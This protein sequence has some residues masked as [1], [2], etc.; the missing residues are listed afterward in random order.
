VSEFTVLK[1]AVDRGLWTV[2]VLFLVFVVIVFY[3]VL[4]GF[5]K[6][7][8]GKP[9]E[10]G[11]APAAQ[12]HEPDFTAGNMLGN[13]VMIVM[14]VSVILLG[15]RVPSFIDDTIRTCVQVLG[16]R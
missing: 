6:M 8:F 2:V 13:A 12:H 1:A 5:G 15:F 10:P 14:A 11:S 4:S 7:L 16:A 9:G 3:G